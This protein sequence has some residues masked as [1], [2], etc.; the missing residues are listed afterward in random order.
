MH[1]D[2][3]MNVLIVQNL[4]LRNSLRFHMDIQRMKNVIFQN[5][6]IWVD[7]TAQKILNQHRAKLPPWSSP[8]MFPLILTALTLWVR[9]F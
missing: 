3:C 4:T 5:V 2:N 1:M 6:D 7:I 9:T 8:A